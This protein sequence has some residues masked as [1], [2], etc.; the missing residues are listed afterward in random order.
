LIL[1][2]AP[3]LSTGN[4]WALASVAAALAS[5]IVRTIVVAR[6]LSPGDIGLMGVAL[7][8]LGVMEAVAST[9]VDTAL[10]ATRKDVERS[11]DPAFTIQL[12]RG[13]V[14][15]A[16]LWIA[17]PLVARL[18][19]DDAVRDV[20]RSVG[21]IAAIRGL[22]NPATALAVRRLEFRRVFWWGLPEQ[23]TALGV[24]LALA[25]VRRDVW[26][27]VIGALVGQLVGTIASYGLVPRLPRLALGRG[28]IAELLQF[29]K[30]VSASRALMYFSVNIDAATVGLTMGTYALGLYQFATR[31]AEL[32][33]TTFTRAAS[34]VA[35]P[36]LS[37][38]QS[39]GELR[40]LWRSMLRAVL[41]VNI[42][43]AV[44]ILVFGKIAVEIVAGRQWLTAVP[45]MRILALAMLFRAVIVL[46]G[47][48]LD[49]I[50]RPAVTMRINAFRLLVLA[51]LLAAP[52]SW[53]SLSGIAAAVLIANA[54][55]AVVA[56]RSAARYVSAASPVEARS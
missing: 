8:A 48:L 22:A 53:S 54:A 35:L 23:L 41:V 21:A 29:G 26:A 47:Q 16:L 44:L 27:L 43:A 40:R 30:F 3:H 14:V 2:V 39:Q 24:T 51:V 19:E 4:S 49:A 34:Q 7:L 18:F 20:I 12:T 31:V 13:L 9:G 56:I 1:S 52:A 46:T 5:G 32:P 10:I 11:L 50:G 25:I 36:A 38:Q 28:D 6:F 33:V 37:A 42:A 45:L 55:A 15:F 17:A